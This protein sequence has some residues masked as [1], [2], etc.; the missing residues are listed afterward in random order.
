MAHAY[1]P[2]L[3]VAKQTEVKKERRLPLKG[4]VLVKVGDRVKAETVVARTE[5]PGNVQTVNVANKLSI[6]PEDIERHMLV[7]VGDWVEEGQYI[8]E[9]RSFFGLFKSRC[10]MPVSGTIESISDI[11]GQVIV[12]EKAIPVE[13]NAYVDGEVVELYE[14]E[15]VMVRTVATFVQ[16]IFG[17]GGESIGILEVVASGPDQPLKPEL[18]TPDHK[19]KIVLGGS[20]VTI[21]ALRRAQE[22]GVRGII[23][24]GIGDADLRTILGYDLG[25]AITGSE[26]IG[27][28]VVV[29]EGFGKMTMAHRTFDLLTSREGMKT[30]I[31]GATQIRAG[32]IRPEV[33]IPLDSTGRSEGGNDVEDA[34]STGLAIGSY[35]RVIREPYFGRIG[36][37]TALPPELQKLET[38]A[39]VRVLEVE[40]DDGTRATIPRANVELIEE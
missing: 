29:T 31:S 4:E 16:G 20:L 24:G 27:L 2:G 17:I 25:V 30:S 14:N 1:T 3:R 32:V 33:V 13:V 37:V 5:L 8:A 15:G 12:R 40:F 18:I 36:R 21:E 10:T 26:E 6:L 7:K 38:E 34:P 9:S 19:G 22:V 11:T 35:V 23:A 28:T 39:M